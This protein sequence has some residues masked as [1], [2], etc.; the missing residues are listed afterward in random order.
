MSMVQTEDLLLCCRVRSHCECVCLC[1]KRMLVKHVGLVHNTNRC[2]SADRAHITYPSL[3][4]KTT[5]T[6]RERGAAHWEVYPSELISSE[7]MQ[8]FD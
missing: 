1:M 6:H 7:S 8:L 4:T 2:L 3:H 5:Y